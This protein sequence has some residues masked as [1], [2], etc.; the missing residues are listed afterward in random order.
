[1]APNKPL[2]AIATW[3]LAFATIFLIAFPLLVNPEIVEREP[4]QNRQA[5]KGTIK[6]AD[7]NIENNVDSL[8]YDAHDAHTVYEIN[9][10]QTLQSIADKYDVP[11]SNL[12]ADLNIPDSKADEKLGRLKRQYSFTMDD[13][14]ESISKNKN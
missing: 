6:L 11:V 12:A 9:G 14:R 13:V 7:E 8:L 5:A 2:R 3:L 1:M 10:S 4:H